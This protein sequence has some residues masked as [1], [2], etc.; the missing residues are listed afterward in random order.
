MKNPL[1]DDIR[2]YYDEEIPAAMQR[3]A[4]SDAFPLLASYVYPAMTIEAAR[5]RICSFT[6]I[7]DF[8][9][10]TM[11][12]VE[13]RIPP[14]GRCDI[15]S[16]RL[17]KPFVFVFVDNCGQLKFV[18]NSPLLGARA[19]RPRFSFRPPRPPSFA[20]LPS[21]LPPQTAPPVPLSPPAFLPLSLRHPARTLVSPFVFKVNHNPAAIKHQSFP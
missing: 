15:L 9:L 4:H 18:D 19:S 5:E 12:H 16:R 20:L 10:D 1:F 13:S 7:R 3:I 2:P 17:S 8:Q 11:R 6:T 21:T 14:P